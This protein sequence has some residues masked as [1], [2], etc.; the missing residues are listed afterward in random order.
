MDY[1]HVGN[2]GLRVS[3]IRLGSMNFGATASEAEALVNS[4]VSSGHPA[5]PGYNWPMYAPRGRNPI[6]S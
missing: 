6:I 1:A 4:L 5:T 3:G 2:S